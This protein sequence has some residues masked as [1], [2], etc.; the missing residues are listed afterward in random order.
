M[1]NLY[2][3]LLSAFILTIMS[4]K[5]KD[6]AFNPQ[7]FKDP[8]I[9]FGSGGGFTGRVKTFYLTQKGNLY[10][11]DNDKY[12]LL[13]K[14]NKG[15]TSQIFTNYDALG[16]K[17][18]SLNDPGNKYYFVNFQSKDF[19]NAIKWGNNPLENKNLSIYYNILLD[20]VKKLNPDDAHN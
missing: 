15:I 8:L 17:T 16:L 19:N 20:L 11:S 6:N 3:F 2:L 7:N 5:T 14:A 18:L 13:G 1:K 4:C 12:M 10:V 9:S